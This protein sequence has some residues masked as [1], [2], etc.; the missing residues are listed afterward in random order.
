MLAHGS[1]GEVII[2]ETVR[3]R[4]DSRNVT[5]VGSSAVSSAVSCVSAPVWWSSATGRWMSGVTDGHSSATGF[6][7]DAADA[8]L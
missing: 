2:T 7:N 8:F 6:A 1:D 3:S 4:S 5:I